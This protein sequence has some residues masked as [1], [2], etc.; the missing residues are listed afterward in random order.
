MSFVSPPLVK[1]SELHVLNAAAQ[2]ANGSYLLRLDQD[3]LV[4]MSLLLFFS[5][6]ERAG[7]WPYLHQPW[8]SGRRNC[9]ERHALD[10]PDDPA[11]CTESVG[12][13]IGSSDGAAN[14]GLMAGSVGA[15]I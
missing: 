6:A 2:R 11:G 3:I 10:A 1:L 12:H 4:G 7:H 9:D 14:G 8:C 15:R 5:Q 13:D